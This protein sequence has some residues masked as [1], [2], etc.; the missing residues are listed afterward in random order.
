VIVIINT[1]NQFDQKIILYTYEHLRTPLLD[2]V[3]RFF[4]RIGDGFVIWIIICL[5]LMISKKYRRVGIIASIVLLINTILGEV[6]LKNLIERVRPY[7]ALN[8]KIIIKELSS[9]SMP[10]G[11]ALSS[12]SIAFVV[13]SLIK[14][15]KIYMPILILAIIIGLSRIYLSVHY[16]TD[17]LLSI[18]IAYIVS[19][20]VIRIAK[21]KKFIQNRQ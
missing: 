7:E 2:N 8:L 16:P 6:V 19:S 21:H 13:T 11:H 14:Q 4:T 10:S 9:F 18:L 20:I 1:I 5:I 12:F 17:V 15:W 3:M